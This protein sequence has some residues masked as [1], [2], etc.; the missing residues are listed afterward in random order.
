MIYQ[1]DN[2]YEG[3]IENKTFNVSKLATNSTIK[4]P[5]IIKVGETITI[6]GNAYDENG[7]PLANITI[8]VI[9]DGRVYNL[10]TDSS[11]FWSL[12]YKPTHNGKI[13]IKLT[14]NGNE[15][16]LGFINDSSFNVKKQQH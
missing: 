6:N 4:L 9:L 14:F 7:N 2:H 1:G 16:Y 10:R 3:F 11:G 8:T 13:N 5:S 15:I 12:K